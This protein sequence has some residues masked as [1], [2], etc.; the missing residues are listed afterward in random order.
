[1]LRPAVPLFFAALLVAGCVSPA[2]V[3]GATTEP[4]TLDVAAIVAKLSPLLDVGIVHEVLDVETRHGL[5]NVDLY[6]PE[7]PDGAKVP[8]ILVA[9]PYNT[10]VQGGGKVPENENWIDLRLYNWMREQVIPRG[11][12]FAQMDILGTRNSGGCMGIMNAAERQATADVVD[13][14]GEAEWSTGD[15]GMIGKSYLGLSQIGAAVESP[16]HL[17]TIVPISAPTQDYAYHYYGGVPY[18]L[19]HATNVLYYGAYS[20]PPP[21]G[22]RAE[23]DPTY[24]A[25]YPERFACA[26]EAVAGGAYTLGD[27]SERWQE[28]DYRPLVPGVRSDISM[29][30]IHGLADWNVKPDHILGVY[31][32][33]PGP[34]TALLGQWAHD[35]PNINTYDDD[36]YGEREDWYFTLHRWF[37]HWLKGI[38]T[39]LMEEIAGC[40]VQTQGSD[41]TWRCLEAFPPMEEAGDDVSNLT[42]FPQSDGTL[43]AAPGSGSRQY[44]DAAAA[45]GWTTFEIALENATRVVGTPTVTMRVSTTSPWNAHLAVALG[46]VRDGAIEE[47]DWGFRSLRH[48]DGLEAGQPIVPGTAYDVTFPL[49]PLDHVFQPGDRLAVVFRGTSDAAPNGGILPSPVPGVQMLDLAG[50]SIRL[51][52]APDARAFVPMLAA[53]LPPE[54]PAEEV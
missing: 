36:A 29:F 15:V 49:Y 53:E 26:P 54:Y 12:A 51:P 14:L 24:A 4:T 27:Y 39:G 33:Y 44:V 2:D 17:R 32:E 40:P 37:D 46:V 48:R 34:K 43:G 8:V 23:Q 21:D 19:N 6:R 1:M 18:T 30:F 41:A 22:L 9:S 42:L 52:L 25:R 16:A 28:R 10:N 47:F 20:L 31:N 38:D 3:E 7:M 45:Y 35:Y 13:A 11:Y 50:T 5:V